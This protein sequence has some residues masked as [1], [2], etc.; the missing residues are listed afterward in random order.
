MWKETSPF[1][2][3]RGMCHEREKVLKVARKP[4]KTQSKSGF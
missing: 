4:A 3:G 2:E 1:N